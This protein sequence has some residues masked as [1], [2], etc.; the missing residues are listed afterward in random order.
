SRTSATQVRA[1]ASSWIRKLVCTPK[2]R[3]PKNVLA[4]QSQTLVPPA[5]LRRIRTSLVSLSLAAYLYLNRQLSRRSRRF[6]TRHPFDGN[7]QIIHIR[8]LG[9]VRLCV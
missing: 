5:S 4:M 7:F 3:V 9:D 6:D 8:Q 1:G 2:W